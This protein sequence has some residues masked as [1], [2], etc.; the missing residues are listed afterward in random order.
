MKNNNIMP[1]MD[2]QSQRR[3]VEAMMKKDGYVRNDVCV[4]QKSIWRLGAIIC[5]MRKD[6]WE[7]ETD[8]LV[9]KDG[10]KGRTCIYRLS[11]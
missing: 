3:I 8:Y 7:I 6:G 1:E 10:N 2:K 9:K 5:E 4:L 11:K